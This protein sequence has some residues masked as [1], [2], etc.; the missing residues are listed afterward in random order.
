MSACPR[1]GLGA[2][3]ISYPDEVGDTGSSPVDYYGIPSY[4]QIN[5]VIT[6]FLFQG[7]SKSSFFTRLAWQP[8]KYV[9]IIH[10][11]FFCVENVF[12]LFAYLA[13]LV[14]SASFYLLF[15]FLFFLLLSNCVIFAPCIF[16][17]NLQLYATIF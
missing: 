5:T 15:Y 12:I 7:D 2:N 1:R 16:L 17:T 9:Q 4:K 8:F 14:L 13:L 3:M 10:F 6:F 11:F